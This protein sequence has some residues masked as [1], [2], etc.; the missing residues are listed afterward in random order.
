MIS[1]PVYYSA[2][3]RGVRGSDH[4]PDL[5]GED[6]GE[7]EH[8]PQQEDHRAGQAGQGAGGLA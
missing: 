2:R 1:Y 5:E 3:P 6:P 4:G 8:G 7:R